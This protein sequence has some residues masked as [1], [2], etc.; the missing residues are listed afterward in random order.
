MRPL[1]PFWGAWLATLALLQLIMLFA[2]GTGAQRDVAIRGDDL[3]LATVT[4]AMPG[5][6][7]VTELRRALSTFPAF[8]TSATGGVGAPPGVG[9]GAL[10]SS[11]TGEQRWTLVG[12]AA[13]DDRQT[14]AFLGPGQQL[15]ELAVGERLEG[16]IRLRK[17]LAEGACLQIGEDGPAV[18]L[19]LGTQYPP[20]S[21]PAGQEPSLDQENEA[22]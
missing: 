1:S 11:G 18:Y 6:T 5:Q 3:S 17:V 21:G 10:E 4:L 20:S 16:S 7:D 22:C 15:I 19:R 9:S 12:L 8:Q 14:A 2:V 13:L